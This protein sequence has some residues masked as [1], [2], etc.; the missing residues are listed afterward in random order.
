MIAFYRYKNT[1]SAISLKGPSLTMPDEGQVGEGVS[2]KY[3]CLVAIK[4]IPAF[5]KSVVGEH[6][7][8]RPGNTG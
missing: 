7:K 6:A 2:D 3:F 4:L 5:G 8:I 1:I